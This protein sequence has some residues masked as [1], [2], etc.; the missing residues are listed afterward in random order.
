MAA[1]N[2]S[3]LF[4]FEGAFERAAQT[5]LTDAGIN[6]FISQQNEKIPVINTQLFCDVGPAIDE[7][8]I[9]P[10]GGQT[11][12]QQQDYFRYT[13]GLTLQIEVPR[14]TSLPPNQAGVNSF[15]AQCRALVRAAFMM[16][17]WP[18]R[19]T[20]LPFCRVSDIRPNGTVTGF[21]QQ[22][23]V[24]STTLRFQITFAIQPTA[25]PSGFPPA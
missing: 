10:L 17:Q 16:S 11:S 23:N 21:N 5:I 25:W 1:R 9:L 12:Q 7:L 3:E 18:F 19:D 14:D 22:R 24:D 20:N 6:S 4:D 8:T 15:L 2:L 13:A